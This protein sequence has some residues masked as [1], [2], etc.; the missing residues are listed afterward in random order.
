MSAKR[1]E[2]PEDDAV[3][4]DP[5]HAVAASKCWISRRWGGPLA[6][7]AVA[8][9]TE[10]CAW[11]EFDPDYIIAKIE[12]FLEWAGLTRMDRLDSGDPL[13][14]PLRAPV[15]G[16]MILSADE[17]RRLVRDAQGFTTEPLTTGEAHA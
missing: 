17:Q 7:S 15:E 14:R 10:E 13:V 1:T 8:E 12:E 11:C 5:A 9:H 4:R 2:T 3:I 6:Q 16:F